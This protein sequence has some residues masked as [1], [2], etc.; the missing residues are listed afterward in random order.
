MIQ[1]VVIHHVANKLFF[2][3]LANVSLCSSIKKY[4]VRAHIQFILTLFMVGVDMGYEFLALT[5][6]PSVLP[7]CSHNHRTTVVHLCTSLFD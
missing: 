2:H 4:S 6:S 7:W 1:F 5:S 3:R